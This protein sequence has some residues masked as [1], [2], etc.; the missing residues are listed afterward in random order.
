MEYGAVQY[1]RS[2]ETNNQIANIVSE[3]YVTVCHLRYLVEF[4]TTG[5]TVSFV[6]HAPLA[7]V[8]SII[9]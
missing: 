7:S 9:T 1:H 2:L 4:M 3:L 8:I 6:F 5:V